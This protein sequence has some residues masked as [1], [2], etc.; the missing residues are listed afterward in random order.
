MN[1]EGVIHMGVVAGIATLV[2]ITYFVWCGMGDMV[3]ELREIWRETDE[4]NK[5]C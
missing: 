5:E 1:K 4:S 2:F 3:D